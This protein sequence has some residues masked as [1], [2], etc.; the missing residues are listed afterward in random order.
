MRFCL[1]LLNHAALTGLWLLT[2]LTRKLLVQVRYSGQAWHTAIVDSP[3]PEK[4]IALLADLRI[5]HIV[6]QEEAQA[7]E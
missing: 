6:S 5:D 1:C 3:L 4:C 7:F 2:R